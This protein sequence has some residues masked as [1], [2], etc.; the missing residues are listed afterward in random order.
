M[1]VVLYTTAGMESNFEV[2]STAFATTQAIEY[3]FVSLMH[4]DAYAFSHN[5]R[6]TIELVDPD[7]VS[8]DDMG[9]RE[10]F[11]TGDL[12]HVRTLYCGDCKT[13]TA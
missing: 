8:L 9:Q 6:P 12:Q 10:G 1:T 5:D 11:S 13:N 4:Y 3:D 2:V 7:D